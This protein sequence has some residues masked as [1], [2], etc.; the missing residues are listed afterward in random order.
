MLL[1]ELLT[2]DGE[3]DQLV[4]SPSLLLPHEVDVHA[5]GFGVLLHGHKSVFISPATLAL[6]LL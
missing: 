2:I 1:G 6:L 4:D 3:C 5:H